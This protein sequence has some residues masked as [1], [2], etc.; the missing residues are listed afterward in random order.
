M[1]YNESVR[2]HEILVQIEGD[3]PGSW[4]HANLINA[5]RGITFSTEVETDDLVDL[6]DQSAPAQRTRTVTTLD[7]KIDGSGK[8][9]PEETIDWLNKWK[10]GVPFVCR[11]TDG[12]VV[13]EG[14]F[15][16]TN[17]AL[18]ADRTK[19]GENTITLEQAGAVTVAAV[20]P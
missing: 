18:S 16:L 12:Y 3:T 17:F 11:V 2:G 9:V 8:I 4:A 5:S 19:L 15:V 20:A 13:V 14:P 1:A 10:A 7:V 6:A